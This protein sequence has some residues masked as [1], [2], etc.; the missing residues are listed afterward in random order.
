MV[1]KELS[2]G[3]SE[4]AEGEEDIVEGGVERLDLI[5]DFL[6]PSISCPLPDLSLELL[7]RRLPFPSQG[8]CGSAIHAR[9]GVGRPEEDCQKVGKHLNEAHHESKDAN[10][11]QVGNHDR[12][13]VEGDLVEDGSEVLSPAK[14]QRQQKVWSTSYA[15]TCCP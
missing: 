8:H 12:G 4:D 2:K 9:R 14:K 13:D 15:S 11:Y 7:T 1:D 10:V 5:A 6:P 3:S